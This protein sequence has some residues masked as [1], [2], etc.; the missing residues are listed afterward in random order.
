MDLLSATSVTFTEQEGAGPGGHPEEALYRGTSPMAT[1][2]EEKKL[3]NLVSRK[4]LRP[5][6][7]TEAL[8]TQASVLA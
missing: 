5:T 4:V 2:G 6:N 3:S 7:A 8:L 1:A